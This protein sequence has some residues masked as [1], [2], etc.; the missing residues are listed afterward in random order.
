DAARAATADYVD[1]VNRFGDFQAA[2]ALKLLIDLGETPKD[3][4]K[5]LTGLAEGRQFYIVL[6]EVNPDTRERRIEFLHKPVRP[7]DPNQAQ[8]FPDF[9][10]ALPPAD[11]EALARDAREVLRV[12][13]KVSAGE[14][15]YAV[16]HLMEQDLYS[17]IA[18]AKFLHSL[19]DD[20]AE[21]TR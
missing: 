18:Y 4:D 1:R 10:L 6:A 13:P 2:A 20:R 17:R 14:K 12:L 7:D 19:P 16:I 21:R 5:L 15:Q 11:R 3:R 9:L 8:L